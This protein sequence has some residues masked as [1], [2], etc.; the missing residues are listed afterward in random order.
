M[1][2]NEDFRNLSEAVA[3]QLVSV[4][5]VRGSSIVSVPLLYPS[6]AG[7]VVKISQHADRYFVSD[8][9][10]GYQEAE[11]LGALRSFTTHARNLADHYGVHFDNQAFFVA[12]ANRDS[13]KSIITIVANCSVEAASVAALKSAERRYSDDTELLYERLIRVFPREK[14]AKNVHLIGSSSHDWPIAALVSTGETPTIF[15]PV[16]NHHAS[17]VNASAKFHDFARLEKPPHRVA[18]VKKLEDMDSYLTLLSQAAT[19][20]SYDADNQALVKLAA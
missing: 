19:V 18:V 7:A 4:E 17:V 12:Q 2:V 13:L 10:Y 20:I 6:G 8:L 3:R 5:Y 15:E 11:M 16:T 9:G 1:I 14:V